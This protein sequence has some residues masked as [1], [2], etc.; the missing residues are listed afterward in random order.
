MKEDQ[1]SSQ[2]AE[3][4]VDAREE[5]AGETQRREG[6]EGCTDAEGERGGGK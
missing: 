4:A 2:R 6:W 5:R 1:W 3:E